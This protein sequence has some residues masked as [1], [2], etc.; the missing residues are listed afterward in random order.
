MTIVT[1]LGLIQCLV[2]RRST[3]PIVFGALKEIIHLAPDKRKLSEI[4]SLKDTAANPGSI[5]HSG[6]LW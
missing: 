2:L 6:C 4:E 1:E 5:S 3:I